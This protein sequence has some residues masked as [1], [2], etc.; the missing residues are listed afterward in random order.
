MKNIPELKQHKICIESFNLKLAQIPSLTRL[1]ELI[2]DFSITNI[3]NTD[4]IQL[5]TDTS[6]N[7]FH[8][9]TWI[10]WSMA[11]KCSKHK[12]AWKYVVA[13]ITTDWIYLFKIKLRPNQENCRLNSL[14]VSNYSMP[15]RRQ[16][17]YTILIQTNKTD[18]K[19]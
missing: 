1:I 2:S 19:R 4:T 10:S 11:I 15:N 3:S 5:S 7:K 17:V 13:N 6:A 12:N 18:G 9:Y 8:F 16:R 14:I